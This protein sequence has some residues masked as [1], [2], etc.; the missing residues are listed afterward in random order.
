LM[1][2]GGA[3]KMLV[4]RPFRSPHHTASPV[5]LVGGGDIP[6]PGEISLAHRGVLFLDELPE[7]RR[8]ALEA[9]R[10]PLE[11][12]VVHVN[13]ARGRAIFP[14]DFL[15]ITAMNPCPCG[16]RGHPKKECLCSSQRVQRYRGKISA[17]L[18]DRVDLHVELPVL[19]TE[20]LLNQGAP[21]ESSADVRT[22]VEAAR[23][24]QGVRQKSVA[25]PVWNSRLR[26]RALV[27]VCPLDAACQQLLGAAVE[28]LGLSARAFDRIR[29]VART[30]ADLEGSDPISVKHLAEAIQFRLLDRPALPSY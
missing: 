7:F 11:E 27:E 30:I 22:R 16:H 25:G 24:R 26:A 18:M 12:G 5:A 2:S 23:T 17:P 15:L 8:D 21:A 14:A 20:E 10:Q 1:G 4:T 29:R 13:R 19:R 9:L 6:Q 3:A 28:R